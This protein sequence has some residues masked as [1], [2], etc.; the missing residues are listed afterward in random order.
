LQLSS[1]QNDER[2]L[3]RWVSTLLRHGANPKFVIEQTEKSEVQ[4]TS[5]AKVIAR[6]LKKYI[7]DGETSTVSCDECG[8]TE[9]IFQE[10]CRSCKSCGHS[11]CG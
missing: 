7:P 6:V 8:S 3:T 5:F 9:V 10:G 2:L 11:K 4:I 1:E